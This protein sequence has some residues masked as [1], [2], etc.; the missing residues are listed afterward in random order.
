MGIH[1]CLTAQAHFLYKCMWTCEDI[2]E[3]C[4]VSGWKTPQKIL[5][6]IFKSQ[7]NAFQ[8]V[9]HLCFNISN[10]WK[11]NTSL[12]PFIPTLDNSDIETSIAYQVKITFPIVLLVLVIKHILSKFNFSYNCPF[13]IQKLWLRFPKHNSFKCM[14]AYCIKKRV[15]SCSRERRKQRMEEKERSSKRVVH[16]FEREG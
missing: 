13:C 6:S 10:H 15:S 8:V 1:S 16:L 11:I 12:S 3:I 4:T 2:L 7:Q 14:S 5:R 9:V